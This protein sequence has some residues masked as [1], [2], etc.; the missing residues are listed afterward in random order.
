ML[1]EHAGVVDRLSQ[2]LLEDLQHRQKRTKIPGERG[3]VRTGGMLVV[4]NT[5]MLIAYVLSRV[6]SVGTSHN[7][8]ISKLQTHTLAITRMPYSS[9]IANLIRAL[10][11]Q[12]RF[13]K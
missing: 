5:G 1:D 4:Y 11:P 3:H 8:R 13:Q 10:T 7:R 12:P 6:T 2:T 9:T